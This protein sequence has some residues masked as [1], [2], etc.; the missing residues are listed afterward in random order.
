MSEG[1]ETQGEG[2]AERPD[3][4][5]ERYATAE[6][7]AK[8]YAEARREMNRLQTEQ[9]QEREA[10]AQAL[11]AMQSAPPQQFPVQQTPYDPNADPMLQAYEEAKQMGDSRRELAITMALNQQMLNQALDQRFS[12]LQPSIDAQAKADVDHA[13]QL[14]EFRV[15]QEMDKDQPGEYSRVKDQIAHTLNNEYPQLKPQ[16]ADVDKWVSALKAA[17]GLSQREAMAKQL[18]DLQ[19]ANQEK[20]AQMGPPQGAPGRVAMGTPE[21]KSEWEKIMAADT[22]SYANMR[23]GT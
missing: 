15:M 10:F 7:Q 6:D 14:A 13:I 3:W 2:A 5:E 18:A 17:H 21:E 8:A 22:N 19:Q 23:R 16:D 9:Q 1:Q 4:L 11:E 12:S 20:Q